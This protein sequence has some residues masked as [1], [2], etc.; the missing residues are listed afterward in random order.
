MLP[1]FPSAA[2]VSEYVCDLE[3]LFSQM[4]VDSY[5]ATES[6]LWLMSKILQRTRGVAGNRT[7]GPQPGVARNTHH[8]RQRNPARSGGKTHSG[9]S[10]RSGQGPCTTHT[11]HTHT[12]TSRKPQPGKPT[13]T[14]H[15]RTNTHGRHTHTHTTTT[16][17]QRT[18]QHAPRHKHTQ[19][20]KP[21]TQPR[22]NGH[23][24]S[25]QNPARSGG[26]PHPG[27][28][29]RNGEGPPTTNTSGPPSQ[30]W[31]GTAPGALTQEWRGN[32]HPGPS[33]G[34]EVTPQTPADLSQELRRPTPPPTPEDSSQEWRGA[35][36]KTLSQE[37]RGTTRRHRRRAS[38]RSGGDTHTSNSARSGEEPP[39][40]HHHPTPPRRDG[41]PTTT[42]HRAKGGGGTKGAHGKRRRGTQPRGFGPPPGDRI[43]PTG[44]HEIRWDTPGTV[45]QRTAVAPAWGGDPWA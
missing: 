32:A 1:E 31:R 34:S 39:P 26:E 27:P 9:T 3:Y 13:A 45:G 18:H 19:H 40:H 41:K 4:H 29:A 42:N 21:P 38:A 7:R 37:W 16:N 36:P 8:H 10:A 28:S 22:G 35:T 30:E 2:R 20:G 14:R 12:Y 24:R 17:T 43:G 5:G 44:A 33:A 6:H 11:S 23:H 15:T 25:R